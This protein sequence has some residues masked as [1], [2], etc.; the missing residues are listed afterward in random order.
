MQYFPGQL[1]Q[2]S[3]CVAR[4]RCQPE[5]PQGTMNKVADF[6]HGVFML[7]NHTVTSRSILCKS[8]VPVLKDKSP[9][10]DLVGFQTNHWASTSFRLNTRNQPRSKNRQRAFR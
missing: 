3:I 6:E 5:R 8:I 10:N 4:G 7:L 2:R 1:F 9:H